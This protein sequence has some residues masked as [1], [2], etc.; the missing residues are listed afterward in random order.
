M[1]FEQ[2]EQLLV[3]SQKKSISKAAR[4]LF[5]GQSTLSN[6]LH[7]LEEEIGVS[8]FERTANGVEPTPECAEILILAKEILSKRDCI[9]NMKKYFQRFVWHCYFAYCSRLWFFVLRYPEAFPD[10]FSKSIFETG[11]S[12]AGTDSGFFPK[13]H[14]RYRD[15]TLP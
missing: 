15:D 2:L 6:S 1:K 3:I 10:L 8:L 12:L 13:R 7:N 14:H 11:Y 4:T 9:L 5:L